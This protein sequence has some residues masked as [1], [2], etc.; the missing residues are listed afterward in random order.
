MAM[1]LTISFSAS[2]DQ[3]QINTYGKKHREILN[4]STSDRIMSNGHWTF[5]YP[6][7]FQDSRFVGDKAKK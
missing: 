6:S 7:I 1:E 3:D 4:Y 5:I 2:K